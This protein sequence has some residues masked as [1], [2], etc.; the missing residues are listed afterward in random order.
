MPAPSRKIKPAIV[1]PSAQSEKTRASR[2]K[3]P[4]ID[5]APSDGGIPPAMPATIQPS[6]KKRGRKPKVVVA[7]A[8]DLPPQN[9]ADLAGANQP[10]GN[11][12][13]GPDVESKAPVPTRDPLPP[14]EGRNTHPSL[15]DGVQPTLRRLPQEVAADRKR[16]R[17]ELEAK[18]QAA[19]EA[20][21]ILAQMELEDER[22][23]QAV[24]KEG[25]RQLFRPSGQR[26]TG[27]A[28]SDEDIEG[29][30]EV[31]YSE[32][33]EEDESEPQAEN[34]VSNHQGICDQRLPSSQVKAKGKGRKKDLRDGLRKEIK[35]KVKVLRVRGKKNAK[36]TTGEGA[37]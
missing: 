18:L 5:S 23:E 13:N 32:G 36:T 9:V 34:E 28:S 29:V 11:M 26:G 8:G 24:D 31:D 14:R 6:P 12:V 33:E 3:A 10:A 20:K 19:E 35:D 4:N 30:D 15:Q 17:L 25:R 22:L 27:V 16:K 21:Q 1:K 2:R 37:K 7:D